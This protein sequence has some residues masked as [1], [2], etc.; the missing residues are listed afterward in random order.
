LQEVDAMSS[1][2]RDPDEARSKKKLKWYT[3]QL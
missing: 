2:G 3:K 1:S